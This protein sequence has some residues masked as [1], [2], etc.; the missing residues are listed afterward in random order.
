[1]RGQVTQRRAHVLRTGRAVQANHVD[2]HAFQDGQHSLNVG[3]Q[4]HTPVGIQRDLG[5]NGQH[6]AAFG[7]GFMD[8]DDGGFYF[9]NILLGFQ[10]H[11]IG[12][13]FD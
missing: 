6:F 10:Q 5:L 3:A 1:M 7:E 9:Q 2:A 13:A 8:A 4:Q 11:E 12:A